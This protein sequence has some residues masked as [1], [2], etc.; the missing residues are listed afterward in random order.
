MNDDGYSESEMKEF[1]RKAK[2]EFGKTA[3]VTDSVMYVGLAVEMHRDG[4]YRSFRGM[5]FEEAMDNAR[6][7][8]AG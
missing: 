1:T 4:R 5:T 6:K 2:A 7:G 3:N 8:I